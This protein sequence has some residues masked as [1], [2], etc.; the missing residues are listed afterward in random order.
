MSTITG[1]QMTPTVIEQH[2][3][4]NAE[5]PDVSE[6]NEIKLAFDDLINLA[7]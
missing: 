1:A 5:F 2:I 7:T 4:I 3:E 6:Y